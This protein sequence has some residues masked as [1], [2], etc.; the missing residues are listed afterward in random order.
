MNKTLLTKLMKENKKLEGELNGYPERS[1]AERKKE[2]RD[3]LHEYNEMKDAAQA[4]IGA[5]ANIDK[6]TIKQVH[7]SLNLPT[8]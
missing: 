3:M 1:E 4:I 2:I 6:V 7:A 8:D 5:L